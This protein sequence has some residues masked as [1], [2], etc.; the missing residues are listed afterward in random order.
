MEYG[1]QYTNGIMMTFSFVYS[2]VG[3]TH[4]CIWFMIL[5]TT[6]VMAHDLWQHS[7]IS[8]I[9]NGKKNIIH[10]HIYLFSSQWLSL[11]AMRTK[12]VSI[13]KWNRN[14]LLLS[15]K[16]KWIGTFLFFFSPLLYHSLRTWSHAECTQTHTQTQT[17]MRP[18]GRWALCFLMFSIMHRQLGK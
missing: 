9:V 14:G 18:L 17:H 7:S 15:L 8:K 16:Y 12:W 6:Y 2:S 4:I 1:R 13:L 11:S 3:K 10:I 5:Q